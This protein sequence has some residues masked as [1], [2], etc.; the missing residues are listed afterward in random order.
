M[1]SYDYRALNAQGRMIRGTLSATHEKDLYYQ[2]QTNGAELIECRVVGQRRTTLSVLQPGIETTD[3]IQLC[4]NMEQLLRA[5]VPILDA[6][7]DIR[8]SAEKNRLRDILSGVIRDV[9]GGSALS[10]AFG[11]H[12]KTFSEL[13]RSLIS[14]GEETG[15][16]V[17]AFRQLA[18]HLKWSEALSAR[19]RKATR[20][21]LIL[22]V[23]VVLVIMFMMTMVVPEIVVFLKASNLELP[24]A[25]LA[26]IAVS[27]ALQQYWWLI[28]GVPL[29]LVA[30]IRAMMAASEDF[31][32]QVDDRIL[33]LPTFGPLLR[34]MA[35]AQFA[36]TLAM[37]FNSGLEILRSI[38]AARD[39]LD[40][41]VLRE[42]VTQA[43][44]QVQAGN[45][46]SDALRSS[47]EMPP[48]I[49]RMIKIGETSGNLSEVLD[50][51]N[52]IYSKDID[53]TVDGLV[54]KIEPTLTAVMGLMMAWI[55]IGVFMPIYDNFGN[56]AQ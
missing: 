13:F 37:M 8:D 10:V 22:L 36:H 27:E 2:L 48:L 26:L 34:K 52:E 4:V 32:Y 33:R 43:R 18:A 45:S 11:K 54:S 14:A 12:P 40:N 9:A 6:F 19:V 23:V 38:D 31:A 29:G 51:V 25:T 42:A 5:G 39:T 3:L 24:F 16:L 53:D 30:L 7:T 35:M 44:L 56:L 20:Y 17:G 15:N 55:A 41:R 1:P 49:L 50:Q 21:P 28:L 46:L 47:G